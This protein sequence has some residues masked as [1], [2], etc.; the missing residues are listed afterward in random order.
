MS[1]SA[2]KG[3]GLV[4]VLWCLVL[5]SAIAVSFS[6]GVRSEVRGA[7]NQLEHAQA[8]ALA[9]AGVARGLWALAERPPEPGR[10]PQAEQTVELATGNAHWQL[11]NAAGRVD[12]NTAS[13]ILL[14]RLLGTVVDEPGRRRALVAAIQDWRDS[15]SLRRDQG[16]EDR[17]YLAANAGHGAADRPFRHP[18]ELLQVRGMTPRVYARI[19]RH[20][21]VHSGLAGVNPRY[22]EPA[23]L[24]LLGAEPPTLE[25]FLELRKNQ[26]D[27]PMLG[28]LDVL[29]RELTAAGEGAMT[30]VRGRGV[31]PAGTESRAEAVVQW[32]GSRQRA[33]RVI[34]W[35]ALF[36]EV[37]P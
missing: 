36:A 29:P 19:G 9:E 35:R 1:R 7:R 5:L 12:L 37:E 18:A 11:G 27:S 33:P 8:Q 3:V 2:Q 22:A 23:L 13:A 32:N 24:R 25:E 6:F 15:D 31:T 4:V 17:D 26:P 10:A 16:A 34:Q 14:E 21:T 28:A 30:L 20:L